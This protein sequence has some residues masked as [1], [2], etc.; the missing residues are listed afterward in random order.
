MAED[1]QTGGWWARV[2]GGNNSAK[3]SSEEH[4]RLLAEE[5]DRLHAELSATSARL[6]ESES[7]LQAMAALRADHAQLVS[8]R[9]REANQAEDR[10]RTLQLDLAAAQAELES[11]ARAHASLVEQLESLRAADERRRREK[12]ESAK[13]F[14]KLL[15]TQR[16]TR[17]ELI[18]HKQAATK[19]A[20]KIAQLE[21]L[22][23]R[24]QSARDA[25]ALNHKTE[26][27]TMSAEL[28]RLQRALEVSAKTVSESV[29][30]HRQEREK[31][32]SELAEVRASLEELQ[33]LAQ[34]LGQVF[35]AVVL[36][37]H[38]FGE[39][40][41]GGAHRLAAETRPPNFSSEVPK[42]ATEL[43]PS[44]LARLTSF[45]ALHDPATSSLKLDAASAA[46]ADLLAQVLDAMS[47]RVTSTDT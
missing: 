29:E 3:L 34:T 12:S 17:E 4:G 44:A 19:N 27:R 31:S 40:W 45:V 23:E 39:Y 6:T 8:V 5:I 36:A 47:G 24:M 14:Q 46:K 41:F 2:F 9:D 28:T 15:D 32:A 20:A 43:I 16:H 26:S 10:V 7:Q 18:N 13:R 30:S 21:A 33:S 35:D 11:R 22:L 38:A 37:S 25:D 1:Q 42:E